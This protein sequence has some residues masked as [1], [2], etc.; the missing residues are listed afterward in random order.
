M[1]AVHRR[2]ADA[3]P[4]LS[5]GFAEHVP[6]GADALLALGV[7]AERVVQW[8][9]RH[10]PTP[11]AAGGP[12]AVLRHNLLDDLASDPWPVVVER[13]L[14]TLAPFVGAHL[15]HGLI[16][17]AHAVRTLR[18]HVDE[19]AL[20]ELA[21]GLAAWR[22]WA[23][24]DTGAGEPAARALEGSR[25]PVEQILDAA[26]RGAG[27]FVRKSSIF[28]LHA[29]TA[30]MAFLLLADVVD[31]ASQRV[32]AAAFARTHRPHGSPAWSGAP[33]SRPSAAAVA[34]L[35]DHWDAH[36]AKLVEAALRGHEQT[37]DAAFLEAVAAIMAQ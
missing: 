35:S 4:E 26:V 34:T 21:T 15:F 7:E 11:L 36:P 25:D 33:L 14:A 20:R 31:P 1:A 16:R 23:A 22:R 6:M 2:F 5:N 37:G 24:R 13:E 29:V 17:T 30:P 32:A 8:A 9:A 28:T 18:D 3:D 10:E 19:G 27:A 12:V